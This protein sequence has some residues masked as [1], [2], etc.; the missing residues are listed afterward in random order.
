[1]GDSLGDLHM[2]EGMSHKVELTIGYLN[3]DVDA[4]LPSY[5]DNYDLVITDDSPMDFINDLLAELM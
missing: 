5:M 3:H 4:L 2:S 1:M